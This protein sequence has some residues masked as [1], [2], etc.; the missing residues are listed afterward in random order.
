MGCNGDDE[1][2]ELQVYV[3]WKVSVKWKRTLTSGRR[4]EDPAANEK[5]SNRKEDGYQSTEVDENGKR[6]GKKRCLQESGKKFQLAPMAVVY[7]KM[8]QRWQGRHRAELGDWSGCR[9]LDFLLTM[10]KNVRRTLCQDGEILTSP[11]QITQ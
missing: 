6:L 1:V 3:N 5:G 4:R 7:A 8:C 9:G 11:F 10:T 2:S